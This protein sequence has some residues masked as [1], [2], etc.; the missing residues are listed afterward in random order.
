V[1][2]LSY[3]K[4]LSGWSVLGTPTTHRSLLEYYTCLNATLQS[5]DN[6]RISL[7]I[8]FIYMLF[9]SLR[10]LILLREFP[11]LIFFM[12]FK[13]LIYLSIFFFNWQVLVI[14]STFL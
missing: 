7:F 13:V 2:F 1:A 9:Y 11:A 4:P 8:P 12:P 5:R 3:S 14:K 6:Y 10:Y